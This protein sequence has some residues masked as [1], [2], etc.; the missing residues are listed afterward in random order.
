MK[1]KR[2][3]VFAWMQYPESTPDDWL[4]ILEDIRIPVAISPLHDK[5][6]DTETGEVKKPHYHCIC[7]FEG[8]KS[9]A[10]IIEMLEPLDIKHV[11]IVN[12]KA[13]YMRYLCHLDDPDK[14][15][16]PTSEIKALGGIVIDLARVITKEE[17]SRILKDMTS[18][19]RKERVREL[20]KLMEFIEINILDDWFDVAT[21]SHTMYLTKLIAS[22]RHSGVNSDKLE[23]RREE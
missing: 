13:S 15:Q 18:F 20:E 3:R 11:E 17:R 1:E 8:K 7:D 19:I 22:V 10:Q 6:V 5:D 23:D 4:E 14:Y 2:A 16:Y 21:N 9:V 12:S